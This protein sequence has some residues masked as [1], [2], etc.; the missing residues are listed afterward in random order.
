M[1]LTLLALMG[2][3][4]AGVPCLLFLENL[5]RFR[6]PAP[7]ADGPPSSDE[8][9]PKAWFPDRLSVL[10]PARNE[11]AGIRHSVI[12]ALASEAVRVEVVVLDDNSS[13]ETAAIVG[14]M[15]RADERVRLIVG[16]PLP[17]GWNGK[18]HACWQLAA[19]GRYDQFA[20]IDADVRLQPDALWR[21]MLHRQE[22]RCDL[23][24]AFPHQETGTLMEHLLV[25]MMHVVLLCFLPLERMRRSLHPSY[26]AGC[27][28]FFLT[29]QAAYEA[30]GTHASIR[31][32]RHDGLRLPRAY[33]EA[34][35]TTDV[36]DGTTIADCRMYRSASE[37]VQGLL[38]NAHEGI[39][40]ARLIVP[41]TV[42]LVGGAILP[43]VVLPVAFLEGNA[44]AATISVV[45]GCMGWLPRWLA[46]F[47][48]RQPIIG[49]L[50][51]PL[52]IVAFVAL[53]WVA[54][55]RNQFGWKTAWRGR[56]S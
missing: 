55:L 22:N 38:K 45:A 25:P 8:A 31:G 15:A 49:A 54:L 46:V 44:F 11:A 40:N 3:L 12:A 21:M 13:D 20:F 9:R 18:Q 26:A 32:T 52:A 42:L 6:R 39:A 17:V 5:R 24:S 1:I 19:A 51:H 33:R 28:Q 7:T 30:A 2:L 43:L 50:L 27:G 10:I 41:F 34:G 47:R 4:L 36:V 23:L 29:T 35:L 56:E 16:K 53:Q 48:F 14:E 37:V